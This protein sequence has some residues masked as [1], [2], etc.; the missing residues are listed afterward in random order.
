MIHPSFLPSFMNGTSTTILKNH[1]YIFKK[2]KY[3]HFFPNEKICSDYFHNILIESVCKD[4]ITIIF[5]EKLSL[6]Q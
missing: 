3:I 6:F 2:K 1:V 4:K 5:F